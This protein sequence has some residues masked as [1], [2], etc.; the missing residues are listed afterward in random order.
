MATEFELA[1]LEGAALFSRRFL[2]NPCFPGFALLSPDAN[3]AAL[4]WK[5]DAALGFST[6]SQVGVILTLIP[7]AFYSMF[8]VPMGRPAPSSAET[9]ML[10]RRRRPKLRRSEV[11]RATVA[12]FCDDC[13]QL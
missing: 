6:I 13:A 9:G 8:Q 5:S 7:D 3:V 1:P 11:Q 4:I 10:V 2:L 12:C